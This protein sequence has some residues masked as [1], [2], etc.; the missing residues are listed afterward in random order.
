M[1]IGRKKQICTK[2]R[3]ITHTVKKLF[4]MLWFGLWLYLHLCFL[5][6][7]L[8]TVSIPKCPLYSS[9]ALLGTWGTY[10]YVIYLLLC[11]AFKILGMSV[12]KTKAVHSV[13]GCLSYPLLNHLVPFFSYFLVR[14]INTLNTKEDSSIASIKLS[15]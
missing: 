13:G 6:Y 1:Y 5:A 2:L 11:S 8:K 15:K 10:Q 7:W 14:L 12:S 3:T 4:D 9:R